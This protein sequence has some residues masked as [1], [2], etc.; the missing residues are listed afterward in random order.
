MDI[1]KNI[2][3]KCTLK[4]KQ[5]MKLLKS[6]SE[7]NFLFITPNGYFI[8]KPCLEEMPPVSAF[9]IFSDIIFINNGQ[10]TEFNNFCFYLAVDQIITVTPIDS[11][12]FL[13]KLN[14]I[15]L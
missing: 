15:K 8:G 12:S 11:D 1:Q 3:E 10:A 5:I 13:S 9:I 7:S 14:I 6:S 4:E 2:Q